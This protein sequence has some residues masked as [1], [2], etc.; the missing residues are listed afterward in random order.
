MV[1]A[2]LEPEVVLGADTREHGDLF[3]TQSLD[4]SALAAGQ[5]DIGGLE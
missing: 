5:P 2:L 4:P 1:S 3:A